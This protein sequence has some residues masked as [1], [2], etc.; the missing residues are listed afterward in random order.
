VQYLSCVAEDSLLLGYDAVSLGVLL[1]MFRRNGLTSSTMIEQSTKNSS[2][3]AQLPYS[4]P[5]TKLFL[6]V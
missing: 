3:L 1:S 2:K 6:N 5:I 4:F